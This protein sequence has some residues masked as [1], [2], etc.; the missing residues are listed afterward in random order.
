MSDNIS[1]WR[2]DHRNFGEL[3]DFLVQQLDL[4]HAADA[5]NYELMRD[6][7]HYM[8]HYCDLFHHRREDLIFATLKQR[9]PTIAQVVDSLADE[10]ATL[11][12]AGQQLLAHLDG[13]V[14]GDLVVARDVVEAS[15]RAYIDTLRQHMTIEE[16][17]LFGPA[18]ALP[19]ADWAAIAAAMPDRDDPLFGK[20]VE[21]HYNALCRRVR[22]D[23]AFEPEMHRA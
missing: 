6:V 22:R 11:R 21:A 10:H 13:I 4:F 8:T 16:T 3:L 23:V 19:A 5:P 18:S 20:V 14:D 7:L 9:N 12:D 2:Q 1:R 15:G 17:K